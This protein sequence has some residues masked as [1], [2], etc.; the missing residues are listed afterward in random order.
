MYAT[1]TMRHMP[2]IA[3]WSR[4]L[5]VLK[6]RKVSGQPYIVPH[7]WAHSNHKLNSPTQTTESSE[8]DISHH[9]FPQIYTELLTSNSDQWVRMSEAIS[10]L[11]HMPSW[12]TQD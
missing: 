12:G 5:A 2:D 7:V 4:W 11:L 10:P 8:C 3:A 6:V 9:T 1:A